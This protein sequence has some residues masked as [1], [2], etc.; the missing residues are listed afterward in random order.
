MSFNG[1]EIIHNQPLLDCHCGSKRLQ[2]IHTHKLLLF[3]LLSL[4]GFCDAAE[5]YVSANARENGDGTMERPL[6]TVQEAARL[7]TPGDVCVLGEGVYRETIRPARSGTADAPLIFRCQPG[8]RAVISGCEPVTS[9]QRDGGSIYRAKVS[10]QLGH[11]NQVFASGRMLIEARWPNT[12]REVPRGLLEFD[13][14]RMTKGTTATRIVD[15]QLPSLD[16][17]GA[18]VWVSSYK[19]W[20]CWTGRVLTSG[21]GF[22]EVEDNS[23]FKGNHVCK[24]GGYYCVFGTLPLLDQE[25]EWFYDAAAGELCLWATGDRPP[26]NVEVKTRLWAFDLSGRKHIAIEGLRLVGASILLDDDSEAVVLDGVRAEYVYHSNRA[27]GQYRSQSDSGIVL[28]GRGHVVRNSEIAYSSG[29]CIAFQGSESRLINSYIH[30]GNYI[31]A[32]ASPVSFNRGARGNVASHNTISRAGRTTIGTSGF[33]RSLLQYNDVSYAGYLTDDL[34]LTYG[35]GVEGG[36]SEVR[37][38]WFH[39][40]VADNH[41]M[42]LYF[43]HGCKNL[44]FH[45]NVIW[46][47]QQPGMINNQYANY[48][49]YYNN[50][51]CD[52]QPSYQSAW[53]AGQ[54]Q[55]LY[56]CRLINNLGTSGTRVRGEGLVAASNSWDFQPLDH[57]RLPPPSSQPVDAAE[58]IPTVTDGYVGRRPDRGAYEMGGAYWRAGHDF[59]NPPGPVDIGFTAPPDRNRIFNAAFYNG[60]LE[61]W[62]ASGPSVT[63][64]HDAHSQ[65]V[66][67]SPAMMGGYSVQ[68]G[69]GAG[70]ITQSVSDL[71]PDTTYEL[72][73]MFRVTQGEAA[74]LSVLR[75]GHLMQRGEPVG[76]GAPHWTRRTLR[77]STGPDQTTVTIVMEKHSTGPGNVH[78]DDPGLQR[79]R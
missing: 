76:G 45:H 77:F 47:I 49:L 44:V 50:T 9:W 17:S 69:A 71:E 34:G 13:T 6:Q 40:N 19:R 20:Y 43:D 23:D 62:T 53:A 36:N 35:N 39:D 24:P 22:L 67:D 21:S 7:M 4:V 3:A 54:A 10:M 26:A 11:E 25:D 60:S 38:N 12:G 14:A 68:F 75:G 28:R 31:G 27:T 79:V 46:H 58:V 41:N 33:H 70:S 2:G 1:K 61:G 5:Y 57:R 65:W 32:Y 37:Y 73:A 51:V 72:M 56:G 8:E 16:W 48:L 78:L 52:A 66:N 55:D 29:N 15:D 30:D 18:Q 59:T 64:V 42:G 63:V 74:R